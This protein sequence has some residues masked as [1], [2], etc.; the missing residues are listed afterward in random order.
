MPGAASYALQCLPC[1]VL[2][3]PQPADVFPWKGHLACPQPPAGGGKLTSGEKE[4]FAVYWAPGPAVYPPLP[5]VTT[6]A[7]PAQLHRLAQPGQAGP[8]LLHHNQRA[9]LPELKK[10]EFL[11][12]FKYQFQSSCIT[13]SLQSRKKGNQE[14]NSN[15]NSKALTS[16]PKSET[17]T[18][19]LASA[20]TWPLINGGC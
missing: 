5:N 19:D 7:Q 15:I 1:P 12:Q 16:Q 9:I 14:L 11:I 13:T 8:K 18:H 2:T 6:L 3:F 20:G 17:S 10:R 4:T